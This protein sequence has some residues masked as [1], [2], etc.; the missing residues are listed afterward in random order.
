MAR[1][2]CAGVINRKGKGEVRGRSSSRSEVDATCEHR[3]MP[4]RIYHS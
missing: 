2:V 3:K 1:N 4:E